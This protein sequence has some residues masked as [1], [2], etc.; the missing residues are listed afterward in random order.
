MV[1]C[2]F[3]DILCPVRMTKKFFLPIVI[4]LHTSSVE[5][6]KGEKH[7]DFAHFRIKIVQKIFTC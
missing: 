7:E 1:C 5:Y 3:S 4:V 6:G 2:E